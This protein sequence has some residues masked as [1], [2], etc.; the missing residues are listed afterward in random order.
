MITFFALYGAAF[1]ISFLVMLLL[2]IAYRTQRSGGIVD[3]GW[4]ICFVL[5]AWATF[6]IGEGAF[7]KRFAMTA[8]VSVWGGRLGWHLFQRYLVT[9][10]DPRYAKMK[11]EWGGDPSGMLFLMMFFFQAILVVIISTPIL[12]VNGWAYA[13][14]SGWELS[15]I[16]LWLIGV[17]GES[18]SDRQLRDFKMNP[19]NKGKVCDQGLWKFSRHPNYF[20]EFVVWIGFSLFAYPSPF[21]LLAVISP[22]VVYYLLVHG[23]GIPLA[24]AQSLKSR[25]EQYEDY[26]KRTSPFFPWL[27]GPKKPKDS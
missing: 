13:P 12:L 10:E 7:L 22:I 14:W 25:K 20:F 8:M 26:Q 19:E 4:C 27:P 2:W 24:E 5:T 16:A 6:F 1:M 23:S 18:Y 11:Q 3:I 17:V 21:G 9:E 15:G